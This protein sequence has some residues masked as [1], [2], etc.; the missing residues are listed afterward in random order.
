[1]ANIPGIP[2]NLAAVPEDGHNNLSWNPSIP[3]YSLNLTYHIKRSLISGGP[4]TQI[5]TA[6]GITYTDSGLANG[7]TYYYVVTASNVDGESGN[8]NQAAAKPTPVGLT[9][10]QHR[11]EGYVAEGP[12]GSSLAIAT[13]GEAPI[14]FVINKVEKGRFTASG[15]LK[16][17]AL[18][19]P[20]NPGIGEQWLDAVQ[21]AFVEYPSHILQTRVGCIFT[22]V[23]SV[24]TNSG[25]ILGSGI[26]RVRL[27]AH[28]FTIGKTVRIRAK[29]IYTTGG[30]L[31]ITLSLDGDTALT[32]T[33]NGIPNVTDKGWSAEFDVTCR[34]IGTTGSI[35]TQGQFLYDSN[36]EVLPTTAPVSIDTTAVLPIDLTMSWSTGGGSTTGTNVTIEVLN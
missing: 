9:D 6:T 36:I 29:G 27:P 31:T 15:H 34:S 12:A 16:Q 23:E 21:Q 1:M 24:T 8:S 17:T 32:Q 5:G 11:N 18:Y 28:F 2:L 33:I 35:F 25:T 22:Q 4:Y 3:A 30:N 14:R 13:E 19:P 10:W 7:T 20:N 26:G